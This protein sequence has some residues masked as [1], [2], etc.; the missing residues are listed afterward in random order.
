MHS[1]LVSKSELN[2]NSYNEPSGTVILAMQTNCQLADRA[3]RQPEEML[4]QIA[5]QQ[6]AG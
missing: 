3:Q 2:C 1:T 4:Q 5:L 6:T